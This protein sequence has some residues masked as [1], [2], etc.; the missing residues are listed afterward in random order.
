MTPTAQFTPGPWS[1]QDPLGPEQLSIVA[2]DAP[3]TWVD[4]AQIGVDPLED[5]SPT[6]AQAHANAHLI[7]AAPALYEAL[8]DLATAESTGIVLHETRLKALRA[9]RLARGEG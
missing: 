7:A 6:A 1:V 2:G 4:I 8:L 9:L 5:Y 3:A